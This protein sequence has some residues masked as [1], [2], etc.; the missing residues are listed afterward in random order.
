[1][2][3]TA[4]LNQQTALALNTITNWGGQ[5]FHELWIVVE[6]TAGTGI[7]SRP[8]PCPSRGDHQGRT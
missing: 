7:I 4:P 8:Q 2:T 6:R 3:S 5:L 1:M